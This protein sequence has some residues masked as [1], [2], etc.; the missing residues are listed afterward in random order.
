MTELPLRQDLP[1]LPP[2]IARLP[3]DRGY[4]VPWFVAWVDGRPDFRIIDSPKLTKAI[5]YGLCWVCGQPI[6][7]RRA[8]LVGPMC[9]INRTSAEP[10]SHHRCATFS[11]RAC[12]FLT[13]PHARRREI[14]HVETTEAAGTMIRR[15]PGVVLVWVTSGTVQVRQ[16]PPEYGGGVLFDIGAPTAVEW[17][18]E[19]RPA[20]RAEVEESIRTGLPLLEESAR[21]D[22]PEAL[23]ELERM[24]QR[25]LRYLP[26][27]A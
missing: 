27:A 5:K 23:D 22:G 2:S 16:L 12:P 21:E 25:A 26:A 14:R 15:N 3:R 18:A 1:P 11:A 24:H 13:R 9:A 8:Y 10:P 7:G 20:T 6:I 19:G 4:P 17:W